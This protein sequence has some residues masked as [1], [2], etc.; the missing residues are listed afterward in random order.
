MTYAEVMDQVRQLSP[1]ERILLVE[2][3]LRW[4]RAEFAQL[5][6]QDYIE[7]KRQQLQ[8][9]PPAE[10]VRGMLKPEGPPPTDEE[11]REDYTNYLMRKYL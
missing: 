1:T 11:L 3:I 2:T 7:A 9:I 5:K 4:M 10:L 6:T 8:S